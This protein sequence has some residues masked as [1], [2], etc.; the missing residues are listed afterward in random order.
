MAQRKKTPAPSNTNT[1]EP[2]NTSAPESDVTQN[3]AVDE[4]TSAPVTQ[5]DEPQN[6]DETEQSA[7]TETPSN[8][9]TPTDPTPAEE[10]VAM[11]APID[12]IVQ[13]YS[14]D[15]NA[16]PAPLEQVHLALTS[17]NTL[18]ASE[19][20]D[21]RTAGSTNLERAYRGALAQD[22]TIA[23]ACLDLISQYFIDFKHGSFGPLKVNSARRMPLTNKPVPPS[24][25]MLMLNRLFLELAVSN[26][27]I[28]KTKVDLDRLLNGLGSEQA[29]RSLTSYMAR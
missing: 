28:V 16:L 15:A 14:F 6:P 2:T 4:T 3:E 19:D 21:Q 8:D 12:I 22:G 10:T 13:K 27:Q 29:R 25:Y 23:N 7:A 11:P 5:N 20:P 18:L 17:A 9:N 1:S 26:K 24:Q